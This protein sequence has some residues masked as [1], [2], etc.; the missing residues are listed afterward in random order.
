M[1]RI[2]SVYRVGQTN[3]LAAGEGRPPW[4]SW[5]GSIATWLL[6]PAAAAGGVAL[7]RRGVRIWPLVAALVATSLVVLA[8]LA[9]LPRYRAPGEPSLVVLAA[10]G[11]TTLAGMRRSARDAGRSE[12]GG[13]EGAPLDDD[14]TAT[15]SPP[16]AHE[17]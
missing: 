2:W 5:L 3:D 17:R 15:A 7:R 8:F 1:G 6:V 9:G 10:A 16:V 14:Q 13:A 11:A 4:A 12:A